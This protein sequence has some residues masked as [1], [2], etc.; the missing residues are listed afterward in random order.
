MFSVNISSKK[1]PRFIIN[2]FIRTTGSLASALLA[3]FARI[4]FS[5]HALGMMILS[6][7]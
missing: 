1:E 2:Y 4:L 3:I 5:S 7:M 6:I